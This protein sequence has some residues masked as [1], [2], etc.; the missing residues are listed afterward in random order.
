MKDI[1]F[2]DHFMTQAMNVVDLIHTYG[3]DVP[4]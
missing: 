2:V 3:G 1:E 4:D